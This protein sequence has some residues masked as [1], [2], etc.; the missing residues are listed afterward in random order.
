MDKAS[1][2]PPLQTIRMGTV[3]QKTYQAHALSRWFKP[4]PAAPPPP[5]PPPLID[6]CIVLLEI[7]IEQDE[8]VHA[9][10]TPVDAEVVITAT[11][12][13]GPSSGGCLSDV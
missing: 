12:S 1:G 4:A 9:S 5:P 8:T 3:G 2:K 7:S 13:C 10:I 6:D 11:V